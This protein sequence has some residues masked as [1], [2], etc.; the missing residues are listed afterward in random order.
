LKGKIKPR[1]PLTG[2]Q[3]RD[4]G[5]TPH[6]EASRG[7]FDLAQERIKDLT[8]YSELFKARL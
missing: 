8:N 3:G 5:Q 7:H 6:S 4:K 1:P 2:R